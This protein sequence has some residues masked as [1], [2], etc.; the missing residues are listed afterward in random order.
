[1]KRAI[2]ILAFLV[3]LT[4][5]ATTG[6]TT[7]ASSPWWEILNVAIQAIPIPLP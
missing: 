1:M 7:A 3:L 4:A 6:E 5:C 2:G